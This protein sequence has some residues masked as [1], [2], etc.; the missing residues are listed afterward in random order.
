MQNESKYSGMLED[1]APSLA[2]KS[3]LDGITGHHGHTKKAGHSTYGCVA[4]L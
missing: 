3:L 4:I 2:F 1:C